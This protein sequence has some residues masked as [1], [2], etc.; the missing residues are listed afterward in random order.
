MNGNGYKVTGDPAKLQYVETWIVERPKK[1]LQCD[2][3]S[4]NR[5]GESPKEISN[6]SIVLRARNIACPIL[7]DA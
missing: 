1:C 2:V 7:R 6:A 5:Q 3:D 4:N